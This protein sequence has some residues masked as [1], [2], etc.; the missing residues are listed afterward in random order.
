MQSNLQSLKNLNQPEFHSLFEECCIFSSFHARNKLNYNQTRIFRVFL[1]GF[2]EASALPRHGLGLNHWVQK[3]F[4]EGEMDG[5][6]WL[7]MGSFKKRGDVICKSEK[8]QCDLPCYDAKV[9]FWVWNSRLR[10]KSTPDPRQQ[11]GT[12]SFL[13]LLR[14]E[15]T[16]IPDLH[17]WQN[18]DQMET[19][20]MAKR[21]GQASVQLFSCSV[22]T[23]CRL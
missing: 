8:S 17:F 11:L 15:K 14:W 6:N 2:P 19:H 12:M 7:E 13:S 23:T 16:H 21:R 20:P 5:K 18:M 4:F 9:L 1:A 10:S 22:T 3:G